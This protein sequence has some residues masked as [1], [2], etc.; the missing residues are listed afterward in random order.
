MCVWLPL[1]TPGNNPSPHPLIM[2]PTSWSERNCRFTRREGGSQCL[3]PLLRRHWSH[4][5]SQSASNSRRLSVHRDRKRLRPSRRYSNK[6]RSKGKKSKRTRIR[7]NITKIIIIWARVR[8]HRKRS[9]TRLNRLTI[10]DKPLVQWCHH[11]SQLHTF[12]LC[13]MPSA[14]TLWQLT[15]MLWVVDLLQRSLKKEWKFTSLPLQ[16]GICRRTYGQ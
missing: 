4:A 10:L 6:R 8:C 16:W 14:T 12:K 13:K 7:T 15:G 2:I 1:T 9:N 3:T 5:T 11:H